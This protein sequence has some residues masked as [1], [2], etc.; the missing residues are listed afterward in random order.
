ML[1]VVMVTEHSGNTYAFHLSDG[2]LFV[3]AIHD[4]IETVVSEVNTNFEDLGFSPYLP[5]LYEN[6]EKVWG[7]GKVVYKDEGALH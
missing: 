4:D 3:M 7:E 1:K 6:V 2:E 5:S